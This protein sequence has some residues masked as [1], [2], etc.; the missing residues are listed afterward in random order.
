MRSNVTL[1]ENEAAFVPTNAQTRWRN[2]ARALSII[3][4]LTLG[5]ILFALALVL[6][7]HEHVRYWREIALI[8][9]GLIVGILLLAWWRR[10]GGR[11]ADFLSNWYP[12]FLFGFFF[13]EIGFIVHAIYPGWFDHLLISFEYSIF[14]VHPTVWIERFNSYWMTEVLQLS[15]TTYLFLTLGLGAYFWRRG[16]RTAFQILV[17]S[18]CVAYYIGYVIFVLFPIESPYHTLRNLQTVELSGGP[19]TAIIDWIERYGRVHGGAFPSA[20]VSGSVVVLICAWRFARKVGYFLAPL[21]VAICVAT[22]YGRYHYVVDVV[23]G[24][25]MA[26]IGCAVGTRLVRRSRSSVVA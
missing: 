26:I 25:L 22:V 8:H 3:D 15:Y 18:S 5:Y 21:V 19:L 7:R 11:A 14:G 23:A 6:I 24:I 2:L 12:I 1:S 16:E 20:H 17:V 10:H 9:A 4:R 13:E